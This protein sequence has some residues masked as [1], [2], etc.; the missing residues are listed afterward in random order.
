METIDAV[1][2]VS[3]PINSRNHSCYNIM[4]IKANSPSASGIFARVT[5]SGA[6]L[7]LSEGGSKLVGVRPKSARATT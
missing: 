3:S 2:C 5:S 1:G 4:L 7:S 6:C